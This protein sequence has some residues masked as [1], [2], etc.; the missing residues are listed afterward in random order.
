[1][2]VPIPILAAAALLAVTP[3]F[4]Q[5]AQLAIATDTTRTTDSVATSDSTG[6]A[7]TAGA[8]V[9]SVREIVIQHFRPTD[10]RGLNVFEPPKRDGVPFRGFKL[11]FGAAFTQ[12][13]QGL[14]HS[15]TAAPLMVTKTDAA[16]GKTT[17]VNQNQVMQVGH[18]FNNAVANAYVDAQLAK[19]IRV[20][21]TGYLS[22]RHHQETW[23]K[24]GYLLIDDSPINYAP[25]NTLMSYLT[26]KAGHFEVNYGDAHF[27]R[28]DNGNALYNPL[29]GNYIMD[30]FTTEVGG[31]AY[32]R[33]RGRLDGLFAMGSVTNGE[34]RGTVLNPQ[35]RSPGFVGKLGADRQLTSAVR[36]RL[37]GSLLSQSRAANQTL[38]SGDR[39]GSRYY[40]V[41][42]NGT[43]TEKDQA[44]SG[45]IQPFSGPSAG[46]HA[47]VINPFV[48]VGALEYFGNFERAKGRGVPETTDRTMRQ[49][50]NELTYRF[51][52]DKLYASG[53]YNTVSGTLAGITNDI[54][55][56]RTQLG[57]GWFIN[58]MILL[59]GEYVTQTYNDFPST[60]IRNGG[61][62]DGFMVEGTVA[63]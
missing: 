47:A 33:G 17:D 7:T 63:F 10:Q 29:V 56:K 25:L 11:N 2:R 34:V 49:T 16:T 50:V 38:Y 8:S 43:S 9:S 28:S 51:L 45:S 26:V 37:T 59:K 14:G 3:A 22:A 5:N 39:A 20:T 55:V 31:E 21:L 27:R 6:S 32:V 48:K 36:V 40:D 1:M 41:L 46:L 30:A 57:A 13:F 58:P 18:G 4:A 23:I 15:N 62:F 44:W 53:R 52:G 60:D 24:D 19:G 42:E 12:Q 54:S 61:K 35:R